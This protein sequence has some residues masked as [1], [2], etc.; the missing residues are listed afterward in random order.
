V[1][2]EYRWAEGQSDRLPALAAELVHRQVS[3][4]VATG[5]SLTAIAA[6]AATTTTPIVFAVGTDPFKTGL[7]TSLSRPVGNVTGV[8]FLTGEL[9]GKRLELLHELVPTGAL[10][11]VLF[12]PRNLNTATE[13]KVVQDAALTLGHPTYIL[14]AGSRKGSA[15]FWRA[16]YGAAKVAKVAKVLS[17][18]V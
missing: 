10:I 18:G 13:S 4:L 11:A 14:H 12:N 7:I 17:S 2:I 6:R 15:K 1:A 9:E 16:Q 5:G 3:V 8:Y